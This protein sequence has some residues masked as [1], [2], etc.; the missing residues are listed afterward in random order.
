MKHLESFKIF[1]RFYSPS[2]EVKRKL[3]S[4]VKDLLSKHE[5][6]KEF[7]NA[8]DGVIKDI[9]SKDMVLALMRGSS[10]EWIA[11]SGEFGDMIYKLWKSG[12]FKCKGIV[13]FNG[14]MMTNKLD[15]KNWYPDNFDSNDKGFLY[16]DD[17]IFSGGTANKIDNFL[18]EYGSKIKSISVIY[19]GS[20]EKNKKVKSF[21]RYYK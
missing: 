1:E 11:A 18:G 8:L 3:D 21:F 13:V 17:S 14:K 16:V 10:N 6:G 15:V 4:V 20:K 5:G 2:P 19:D 12:G 9:T 7:F